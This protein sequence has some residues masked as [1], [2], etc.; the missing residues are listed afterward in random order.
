MS[1]LVAPPGRRRNR[2]VV[3]VTVVGRLAPN[4]TEPALH[5]SPPGPCRWTYG[6]GAMATLNPCTDPCPAK[7]PRWNHRLASRLMG[8][9]STRWRAATG[10][11]STTTHGCLDPTLATGSV[12]EA[13]TDVCLAH[14]HVFSPMVGLSVAPISRRRSA[15]SFRRLIPKSATSNKPASGSGNSASTCLLERRFRDVQVQDRHGGFLRSREA[16]RGQH[17]REVIARPPSTDMF[18]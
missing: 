15:S 6:A 3:T 9:R 18:L 2:S 8:R 4:R 13:H 10:P 1:L 11:V 12:R 14:I 17:G 16:G 5:D 7:G